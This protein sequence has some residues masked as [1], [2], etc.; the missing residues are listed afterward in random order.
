[1]SLSRANRIILKRRGYR[2][3]QPLDPSRYPELTERVEKIKRRAGLPELQVYIGDHNQPKASSLG[4]NAVI[5]SSGM[6]EMLSSREA[7]AILGHEIG[8]SA[9]NTKHRLYTILPLLTTLAGAEIVGQ[10]AVKHAMRARVG[11]KSVAIGCGLGVVAS[12]YTHRALKR[13]FTGKREAEAD[14]LGIEYSQD[15]EAFVSAMHKI[16]HWFMRNQRD[17]LERGGYK[18]PRIRVE[19][20]VNA[21][22]AHQR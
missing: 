21:Y 8:H 9:R 4:K 14:R 7:A 18:S 6:Q 2:D 12:V 5:I 20:A 1:M 15:P 17:V 10:Y 16:E 3:V 22:H 11:F 19:E 13:F